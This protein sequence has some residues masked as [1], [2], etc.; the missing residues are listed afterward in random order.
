MWLL[1]HQPCCLYFADYVT[2]LTNTRSGDDVF[3]APPVGGEHVASH[4]QRIS[5]RS[6]FLLRRRRLS[7]GNIITGFRRDVLPLLSLLSASVCLRGGV[8]QWQGADS[9]GQELLFLPERRGASATLAVTLHFPLSHCESCTR[10]VITTHLCPLLFVSLYLSACLGLSS[11]DSLVLHTLVIFFS[12]P[13]FFYR[14]LFFSCQ[15][16]SSCSSFS[17]SGM[18]AEV[19]QFRL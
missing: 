19:S 10:P 13:F 8:A 5:V 3:A 4:R 12:N 7:H 15:I 2:F 9:D 16:F 18:N 11:H 17:F 14:A 6:D 1:G